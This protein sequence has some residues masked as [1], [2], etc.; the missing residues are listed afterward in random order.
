MPGEEPRETAL[1]PES[2]PLDVTLVRNT[3]Q[4]GRWESVTWALADVGLADAR[5]ARRPAAAAEGRETHH[6]VQL[7]LFRDQVDHYHYNLSSDTPRLFVI[8]AADPVDDR[9]EPRLA[10]LSHIEA[11]DYMETEE[12][13]LSCPL[14][15]EVR[16]WVE[17]WMQL[18]PVEAPQGK[19]KRRSRK[20]SGD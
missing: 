10:T 8:C 17:A 20:A 5:D 14:E 16:Q 2:Q 1:M 12:E 15:G 7:R 18:A 3:R 11:A 19:G 6:G 13:V 9:L 4:V